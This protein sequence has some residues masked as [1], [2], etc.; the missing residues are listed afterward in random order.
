MADVIYIM[1]TYGFDIEIVSDEVF[2]QKLDAAIQDPSLRDAVSGLLAY[3]NSDLNVRRSML[4]ASLFYTTQALFRVQFKW[5]ITS[6][7]Y[8]KSMIT[9]L[10]QLGMF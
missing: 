10:D 8:L 5:P 1:Q 6:P 3:K 2:Q 7:D 9:T 4:D